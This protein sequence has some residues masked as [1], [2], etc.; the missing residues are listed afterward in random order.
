MLKNGKLKKQHKNNAKK[1]LD[2]TVL[3]QIFTTRWQ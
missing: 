1:L 3:I 2:F